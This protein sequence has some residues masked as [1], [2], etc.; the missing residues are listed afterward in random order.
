R[1]QHNRRNRMQIIWAVRLGLLLGALT[2]MGSAAVAQ[3]PA[4]IMKK[5]SAGM[6][7]ANTYQATWETT[8]SMGQM[9]SMNLT[10][11][12]KSVPAAGK[13]YVRVTPNGPGTGMMAM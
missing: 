2:T 10:T 6:T 3:D 11:E 9:G 5:A 12:I 4:A 13:S 1:A 7:V 8:T